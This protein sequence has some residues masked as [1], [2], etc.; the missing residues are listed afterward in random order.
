MGINAVR[1]V[2][3]IL[4]S[5]L[6]HDVRDFKDKACMAFFFEMLT[7]VAKRNTAKKKGPTIAG[8]VCVF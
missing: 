5:I 6:S 7:P 3:P 4:E 8:P 1:F 2:H